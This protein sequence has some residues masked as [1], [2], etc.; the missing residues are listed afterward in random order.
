MP[1]LPRAS[2]LA[3]TLL[4]C[5]PEAHAQR[6]PQP[7]A[8]CVL[9]GENAAL[10]RVTV[11]L[12]N[13]P[14]VVL[15]VAGAAAQ[16]TL[17]REGAPS[18]RVERPLRFEG[19]LTPSELRLEPRGSVTD[20]SGA[21]RLAAPQ[22]LL[23]P[24]WD[25][26]GLSLRTVAYGGGATLRFSLA[27]ESVALERSPR[28]A[29]A[30]GAP[31]PHDGP[32][33]RIATR[34]SLQVY[35][36]PGGRGRFVTLELAQAEALPFEQRASRAG[37]TQIR[38]P[39]GAGSAVEGW[40]ASASLRAVRPTDRALAPAGP[41]APPREPAPPGR[42][43]RVYRGPATVREGAQVFAAAGRGPWA[44][45]T[46]NAGTR[47]LY[48]LGEQWVTLEHLDGLEGLASHAW[49]PRDAVQFP[50][51]ALP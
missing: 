24:A 31:N 48:V 40:V 17:R 49:V 34:P 20:L 51:G 37:W 39:F 3:L 28:P 27:C 41:E 11:Q 4:R 10:S 43:P 8:E 14:L 15:S 30:D 9:R 46:Q 35:A 32:R 36:Q 12:E 33:A 23:D 42:N 22:R 26:V 25:G 44:T 47:V 13:A 5:L 7:A 21:L 1:S 19:T 45:L 18:V 38:W 6:P 50:P 29:S 2:A 16:V